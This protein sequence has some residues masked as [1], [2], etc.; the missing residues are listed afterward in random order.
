MVATLTHGLRPPHAPRHPGRARNR[1][2]H[3]AYQSAPGPLLA[4]I[5]YLSVPASL[6]GGMLFWNDL[7]AGQA[8]A[9]AILVVVAGLLTLA[10]GPR[11]VP[12]TRRRWAAALAGALG[13]PSSASG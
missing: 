5:D 9:G 1:V 2:A 8:I 4:A 10:R 3:F 12:E 6:V 11:D 13:R 7:P